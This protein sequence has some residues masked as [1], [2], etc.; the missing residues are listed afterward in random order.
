LAN[1]EW[2]QTLQQ[3]LPQTPLDD[4]HSLLNVNIPTGIPILA[5]ATMPSTDRDISRDSAERR[6]MH[7][8][9]LSLDFGKAIV[10]M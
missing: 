5:I 8:H 9:S 1:S 3:Q 2:F 4:I 6:L 7:Q 10:P